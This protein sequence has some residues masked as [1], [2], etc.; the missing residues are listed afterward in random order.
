MEERRMDGE[1]TVTVKFDVL[2]FRLDDLTGSVQMIALYQEV[3]RVMTLSYPE[4]TTQFQ[5]RADELGISLRGCIDRT[6]AEIDA[7]QRMAAAG[8]A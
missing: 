6:N 7:T 5:R 3:G 2:S 4:L 1:K 8:V